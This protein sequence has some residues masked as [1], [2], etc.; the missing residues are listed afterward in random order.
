MG[1][2]DEK[3]YKAMLLGYSTTSKAYHVYNIRTRSVEESFNVV[4]EDFEVT[5]EQ[6][7]LPMVLSDYEN[8]SSSQV[9]IEKSQR[10]QED[11]SSQSS[12]KEEV[13]EI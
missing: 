6:E 11:N 12:F 5:Y 2:F 8:E 10:D 1:K 9:E 7:N 3:S 4:I 13:E